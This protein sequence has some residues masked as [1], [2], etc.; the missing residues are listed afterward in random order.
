MPT[1]ALVGATGGAGTTRLAVETA[2]LVATTGSDVAVLDAAYATQGLVDHVAGRVDPD[3]TALTTD[4]ADAPLAGGL[5]DLDAGSAGR[6][7]LAPASASFERLARAKAPTA[8]ERF[9]ERVEE[10]AERFDAVVLDVPPL[11][12]NQ[13]VAAV[14]VADRVAVVAPGSTRGADAVG[15]TRGRLRD[16]GSEADLVVANRG[17]LD[18]ADV[19]VPASESGVTAVPTAPDGGGFGTSVAD[20]AAA[21]FETELAV[22]ESGGG[23]LGAARDRL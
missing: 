19:R 3:V 17:G 5:Y 12:A 10:A 20:L 22:E 15:R 9:A 23:L 8:A 14:D 18:D 16:V 21:L 6:V 11:A 7:A 2:A 4:A 1:A 13:A